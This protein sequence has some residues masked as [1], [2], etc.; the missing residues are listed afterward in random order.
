MSRL[1]QILER[2]ERF[3]GVLPS[4]PSDPFQLF[5][6]ESLSTH[7]TPR[8]RDAAYAALKRLRALTPDAMWRVS[9]LK[10]EATVALAGP[11]VEQRL[12]SLR[13]GVDLFRRHPDLPNT[14]RGPVAAALKALKPLPRMS[15]D[16]GAYRMLLF[17]GAHPVMPVDAGVWRTAVRLGYG[18]STGNFKQSARTVRQSLA[19]E[20]P[21]GLAAYRQA[22]LYLSHHGAVTCTQANPH[23]VVCPVL[24]E[25]SEGQQRT[26]PLQIY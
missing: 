15:G 1:E 21:S 7:T 25:C 11:Y 4:P 17:A 18:Q 6:W 14:I 24:T 8:R 10:L 26:R 20:L 5:V 2:L 16:S 12:R 22:Y 13:A 3:Y 23:C 9:Q 19:G